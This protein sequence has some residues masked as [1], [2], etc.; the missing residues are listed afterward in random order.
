MLRA[1]RLVSPDFAS[2]REI[3]RALRLLDNMIDL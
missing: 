3:A 2:S 1:V